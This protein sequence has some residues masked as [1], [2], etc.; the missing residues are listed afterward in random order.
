MVEII[1]VV[2]DVS[3]IL[4]SAWGD[5]EKELDVLYGDTE[6]VLINL[7]M[8]WLHCNTKLKGT[9]TRDALEK[10]LINLRQSAATDYSQRQP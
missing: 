5:Y 8:G 2:K 3:S 6:N 10:D 7:R 1:A 4:D 9:R